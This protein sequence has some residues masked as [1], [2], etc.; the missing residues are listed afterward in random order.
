MKN[1]ISRISPERK[2]EIKELIEQIRQESYDQGYEDG[3]AFV[4]V[5][6]V[7]D[8]TINHEGKLIRKVNREAREGDYVLFSNEQANRTHSDRITAN[9]F[10]EV[11]NAWK[12]PRFITDDRDSK[13]RVYEKSFGRTLENVEVF[14][15]VS[16]PQI[17]KSP[18]QQRAELIQKAKE[19]VRNSLQNHYNFGLTEFEFVVNAE[20]RTVVLLE[21]GKRT[22]KVYKRGVAKCDPS[23]VFNEWIGKAIALARALKIDIPVEFLEAVQPSE[24][25]LGMSVKNSAGTI[26]RITENFEGSETNTIDYLNLNVGYATIIDDTNAEYEVSI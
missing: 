12:E 7:E 22:K 13:Y 19:F 8:N 14:E 4:S 5:V 21:Q 26:T 23:D 10:Y 17:E 15:G 6:T 11:I 9:K 20:K 16:L 3:K 24:Y 1:K 2:I 18:N 25:V